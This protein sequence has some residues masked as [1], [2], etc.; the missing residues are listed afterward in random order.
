MFSG[1]IGK[2][3]LL[4]SPKDEH[5]MPKLDFYDSEDRTWPNPRPRPELARHIAL[6]FL[7]TLDP[8]PDK[9]RSGMEGLRF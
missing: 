1:K 7:A 3:G 4:F 6:N 8:I 2:H 9:I 5:S